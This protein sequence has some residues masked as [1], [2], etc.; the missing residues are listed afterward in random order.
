LMREL[1]SQQIGLLYCFDLILHKD[2]MTPEDK[3]IVM[4]EIDVYLNRLLDKDNLPTFQDMIKNFGLH[5]GKVGRISWYIND[6]RSLLE[7]LEIYNS[8]D[9][10]LDDVEDYWDWRK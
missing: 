3:K 6:L 7:A 9:F 1:K 10:T 8:D 4:N 2:K 5:K